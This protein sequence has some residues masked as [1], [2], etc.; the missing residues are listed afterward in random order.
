MKLKGP[1]FQLMVCPQVLYPHQTCMD[2]PETEFVI[3]H[4]RAFCET[5]TF[6]ITR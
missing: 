1:Y 6:N 5:L 3:D 2:T 4:V